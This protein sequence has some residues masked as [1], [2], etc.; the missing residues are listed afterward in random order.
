MTAATPIACKIDIDGRAYRASARLLA[1]PDT[2]VEV[3]VLEPVALNLESEA[4]EDDVFLDDDE[5]EFLD[6]DQEGLDHV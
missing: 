1:G 3:E 6:W 4:E 2:T 5:D